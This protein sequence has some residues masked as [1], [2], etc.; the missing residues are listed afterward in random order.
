MVVNFGGTLFKL[1]QSPIQ[2]FTTLTTKLV[3]YMTT[4]R[5]N[6]QLQLITAKAYRVKSSD[7]G[8]QRAQ[9]RRYKVMWKYAWIMPI[10]EACLSFHIKASFFFIIRA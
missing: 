8:T 7:K 10:R 3:V 9:S 5:F 2:H 6:I 1:V 4:L